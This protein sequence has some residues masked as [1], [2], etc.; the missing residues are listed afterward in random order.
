MG[1]SHGAA[2][3]PSVADYRATSPRFAQGGKLIVAY[4]SYE[5]LKSQWLAPCMMVW[6][7]SSLSLGS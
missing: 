6:L 1:H 3:D 4:F 7:R 2:Q 5:Y